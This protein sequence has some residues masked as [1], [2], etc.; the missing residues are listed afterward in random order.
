VRHKIS[1]HLA[2][3]EWRASAEGAVVDCYERKAERCAAAAR[4]D[5]RR[6]DGSARESSRETAGSDLVRG[7]LDAPSTRIRIPAAV[8][9][10]SE[11]AEQEF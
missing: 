5:F 4:R 8:P 3:E 2:L 9:Q 10:D 7:Q 1:G 11:E 6:I